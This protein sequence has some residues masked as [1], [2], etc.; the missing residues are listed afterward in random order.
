MHLRIYPGH[1]TLIMFALILFRFYVH[2]FK[3]KVYTGSTVISVEV[4]MPKSFFFLIPKYSWFIDRIAWSLFYACC[5]KGIWPD[6]FTKKQRVNTHSKF[7]LE[8]HKQSSGTRQITFKHK[9]LL[10]SINFH[11][12][13]CF[14]LNGFEGCSTIPVFKSF[15]K[16]SSPCLNIFLCKVKQ[17]SKN[18]KTLLS[19]ILFNNTPTN[20]SFDRHIL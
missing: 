18:F 7:S 15:N 9:V 1:G 12:F 17:G 5:E 8:L 10:N 2:A 13:H 16:L 4:Y 3:T 19:Q 11:F 20:S 6:S 14:S